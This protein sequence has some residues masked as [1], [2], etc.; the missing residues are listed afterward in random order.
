MT[1]TPLLDAVRAYYTWQSDLTFSRAMLETRLK[2]YSRMRISTKEHE[3]EIAGWQSHVD[4]AQ[5]HVAKSRA[6]LLLNGFTEE[7]L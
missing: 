4:V 5:A 6:L 3:A 1:T 2:Q 7:M